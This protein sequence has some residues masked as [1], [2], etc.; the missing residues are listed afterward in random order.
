MT[1]LVLLD[2]QV[3]LESLKYDTDLLYIKNRFLNVS[4]LYTA[5]LNDE[6]VVW[7]FDLSF[8]LKRFMERGTYACACKMFSEGDALRSM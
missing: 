2:T 8:S 3:Y 1:A 5:C 4:N 6:V 7:G